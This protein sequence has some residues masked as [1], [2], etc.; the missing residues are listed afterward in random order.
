MMIVKNKLSAYY[1]SQIIARILLF[2]IFIYTE[3]A[4]PFNRVIHQEEV[5]LYQNPKT[6]SYVTSTHLWFSIV[7]PL[8]CLPILYHFISQKCSV[9]FLNEDVINA[10]LAITLLLPLNGVITNVIK[11]TVGRPRPDFAFRCWPDKGWPDNELVFTNFD[12]DGVQELNCS[13]D[14]AKV[15]QGRKSFPSGHSSFSFAVFVFTFLYLSGKWK[16]FVTKNNITLQSPFRIWKLLILCGILLLPL[17]FAISRTC[18]YHHHW[19]DVTIGSILGTLLALLIYFQ[20]FPSL[21]H[22]HCHL[23][24]TSQATFTAKDASNLSLLDEEASFS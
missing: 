17:C 15:I 22:Q 20:Y 16:I 23:P 3:S 1:A 6:D 8:P 24:L 12:S 5:W 21:N 9:A 2:C 4:E 11:L 19:Q 18:D 7:M 14:R 10:N 13:G